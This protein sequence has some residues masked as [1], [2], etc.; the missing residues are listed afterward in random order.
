MMYQEQPMPASTP[1]TL[2]FGSIIGYDYAGTPIKIP[3]TLA[4]PGLGHWRP[5]FLEKEDPEPYT[6]EKDQSD[7]ASAEAKKNLNPD[8]VKEPE[9]SPMSSDD[10]SVIG[11]ATESEPQVASCNE[12]FTATLASITVP[13][14]QAKA[15]TDKKSVELK[16]KQE[17][18]D[19]FT[20]LLV[21]CNV[22]SNASW[23]Q[24][25]KIISKDPR[26]VKFK[27]LNG[28]KQ[29][30]SD[31]KMRQRGEELVQFLMSKINSRFEYFRCE[32]SFGETETWS[33]VPE[34][35]RRDIYESCIFHLA[36]REREE[37]RIIQ[38]ILKERSYE[39]QPSTSYDDFAKIV[40]ARKRSSGMDANN[41]RLI[42]D[43]LLEKAK[44]AKS[45]RIKEVRRLRK[46]EYEIKDK[47]LKADVSV[48]GPYN[49]AKKIVEHMKAFDVYEKEIG[50]QKIWQDFI[51]ESEDA[52][53]QKFSHHYLRSRESNKN[54]DKN[55]EGSTSRSDIEKE[56]VKEEKSKRKSEKSQ[57]DRGPPAAVK[58]NPQNDSNSN[59]PA[60]KQKKN[61]SKEL[62]TNSTSG[63]KTTAE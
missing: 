35:K 62:V 42:Y 6:K 32:A 56:Q 5:W 39:V 11:A 12:N 8:K 38:Q 15:E 19:S 43:S 14:L 7:D 57:S 52:V 24:C 9:K 40:F 31:Y 18:I 33:V 28:R 47:W 61:F 2:G 1:T 16:D 36:K 10:G 58:E 45:E 29:I 27:Y 13:V 25:V 54:K 21:N 41:V 30:F 50:V 26:Y 48:A 37:A 34:P 22:P 59:S 63:S 55:Q 20:W 53:M 49:E 51:K 4:T 46:F 17:A 44:V 3:S 60:K 23:E